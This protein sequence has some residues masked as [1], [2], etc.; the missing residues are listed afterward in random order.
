MNSPLPPTSRSS[1]IQKDCFYAISYL[2][3]RIDETVSSRR[4]VS[5]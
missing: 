4:T 3:F 1:K 2:F 5:A